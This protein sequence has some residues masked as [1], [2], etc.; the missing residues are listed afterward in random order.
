MR[1]CMHAYAYAALASTGIAFT[2]LKRMRQLLVTCFSFC[3]CHANLLTHHHL[4]T[5]LS[6]RRTKHQYVVTQL[7]ML[8]GVSYQSGFASKHLCCW[9][10]E[11]CSVPLISR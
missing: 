4:P 1:A 9:R 10:H 11:S 2:P 6:V 5:M 7:T 3:Y 8:T